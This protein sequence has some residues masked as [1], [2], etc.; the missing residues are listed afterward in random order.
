[1]ISE[2]GLPRA[3]PRTHLQVVGGVR[4]HRAVVGRHVKRQVG[5]VGEL[6]GVHGALVPTG[7]LLLEHHGRGVETRDGP[8]TR[9][10]APGRQLEVP[11]PHHPA[12]GAAQLGAHVGP[13]AGR[14][15]GLGLDGR[16]GRPLHRADPHLVRGPGSGQDA[17]GLEGDALLHAQVGRVALAVDVPAPPALPGRVPLPFDVVV[18]VGL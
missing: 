17:V 8:L 6:R 13:V 3:A 14:V 12:L 4:P 1:M 9:R 18:V 11:P 7:D 16:R 5:V 2:R 10:G 15:D